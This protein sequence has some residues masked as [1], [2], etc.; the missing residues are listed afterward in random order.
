WIIGSI[1]I[2]SLVASVLLSV[3]PILRWSKQIATKEA[4]QRAHT[5]LAQSVR[6]NYRILSKTNE[7][8]RLT[9][10]ALESEKG[11]LSAY[12]IDPRS[13]SVLAPPKY[14]NKTIND[15]PSLRAIKKIQEGKEDNVS[16]ERDSDTYIVAQ[17]IYLYSPEVND[18]RLEAIVL[19]TF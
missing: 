18:R 7:N 14:F 19:A 12:V 15:I 10:E 3:V 8:T 17:P 13:G 11:I 6:E 5:I 2:I 9:T 1:L 16:I 4:L